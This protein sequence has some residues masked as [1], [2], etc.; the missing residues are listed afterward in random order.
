MLERLLA[1]EQPVEE[2]LHTAFAEIDSQLTP[3]N[4]IHS[5]CTA[6]VALLTPPAAQAAGVLYTANV[7]DARAVLYRSGKAVRLSY[8]HK[9]SDLLE[10]KRV[11]AAGGFISNERVSGLLAVTRSLGDHE[12]KEYVIGAPYTTA[13]ALTASDTLLVVACDGV[14]DILD[15]Q[16]VCE[17][18]DEHVDP[19]EAAHVITDRAIADGSGDNITCMV[20][21]L[22]RRDA[23]AGAVGE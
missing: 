1:G 4:G 10:Q 6:V 15:D 9:G 12:L 17:M 3:A 20:V 5:G 7:G 18:A 13:T 14:W 21:Y 23:Q 16:T 8:D 11:R 19:L 22:Q 2:T